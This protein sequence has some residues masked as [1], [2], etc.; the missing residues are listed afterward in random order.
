MAIL[1][2]QVGTKL[3]RKLQRNQAIS[4]TLSD[5][6]TGF[7]NALKTFGMSA[8]GDAINGVSPKAADN[9]QKYTLGMIPHTSD[10]EYLANRS[11][12]DSK[13]PPIPMHQAGMGSSWDPLPDCRTIPGKP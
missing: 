5:T 3:D 2:A 12:A 8:I 4:N 1:K 10:E 13:C 11:E 9:V 6:G 7:L